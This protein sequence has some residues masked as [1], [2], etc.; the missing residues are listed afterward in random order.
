VEVSLDLARLVSE[1]ET[2]GDAVPH[3]QRHRPRD[4][5]LRLHLGQFRRRHRR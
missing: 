5:R 1:H 2:L 3:P 4:R